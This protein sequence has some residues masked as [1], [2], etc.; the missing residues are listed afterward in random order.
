[1]NAAHNALDDL[2]RRFGNPANIRI[3]Y[4]SVNGRGSEAEIF[5]DAASAGASA[6]L[7]TL[8]HYDDS[9]L[10]LYVHLDEAL[11]ALASDE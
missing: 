11:R 3:C 10:T 4:E 8:P 7:R 9:E 6:V 2:H 1:M 5:D